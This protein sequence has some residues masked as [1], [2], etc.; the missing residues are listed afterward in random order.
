MAALTGCRTLMLATSNSSRHMKD[1]L[2]PR[3]FQSSSKFQMPPPLERMWQHCPRYFHDPVT[4][5]CAGDPGICIT[6]LGQLSLPGRE[7]SGAGKEKKFGAKI[8]NP[9]KD[10][11]G[12]ECI[13]ATGHHPVLGTLEADSLRFGRCNSNPQSPVDLHKKSDGRGKAREETAVE[14]TEA[15]GNSVKEGK[16][17]NKPTKRSLRFSAGHRSYSRYFGLEMLQEQKSGSCQRTFGFEINPLVASREQ[18]AASAAAAAAA[19]AT[20]AAPTT[21]P[22]EAGT[23]RPAVATLRSV[24]RDSSAITI[25]DRLCFTSAV[26]ISGKGSSWEDS[27]SHVD[28]LAARKPW[29]SRFQPSNPSI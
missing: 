12:L 25:E 22:C 21:S 5:A 27:P 20:A 19:T 7:Q 9:Q 16:R 17:G 3:T 26:H 6:K 14:R 24:G 23:W 15:E 4:T 8:M 11:T 13:P 28:V 29:K 18:A 2:E 10:F 1:A